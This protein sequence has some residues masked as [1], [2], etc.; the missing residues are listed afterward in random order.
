MVANK[1]RVLRNDNDWQVET[2]LMWFS[3]SI[4]RNAGWWDALVWKISSAS[5]KWWYYRCCVNSSARSSVVWQLNSL[6]WGASRLEHCLPPPSWWH[7]LQYDDIGFPANHKYSLQHPNTIIIVLANRAISRQ[8][9]QS[10]DRSLGMHWS[11][12]K[13]IIIIIAK[14]S[15]NSIHMV[16]QSSCE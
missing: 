13:Y 9:Q 16:I 11:V 6:R 14:R 5:E 2:V 4:E 7:G 10:K 3:C 15:W 1:S 12:F 8:V